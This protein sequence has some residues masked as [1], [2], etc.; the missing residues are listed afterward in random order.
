MSEKELRD[1]MDYASRLCERRFAKTGVIYPMWHA[2]AG[3]GEDLIFPGPPG[4]KDTSV[5]IVRALFELRD[6]VRYVLMDEAWT[7][8]RL[9]E[10]GELDRVQRMGLSRHPDRVEILMLAGEDRDCGHLQAD[11][12]IIRPTNGRPY[13]G[14]LRFLSDRPEMADSKPIQSSGR[15]VGL[16]PVRGTRQ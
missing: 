1:M 5:A 4:N 13:F 9:I 10:K 8:N 12:L 11:R 14:P 15:L 3:N 6:V 2:V 16:L 7:L